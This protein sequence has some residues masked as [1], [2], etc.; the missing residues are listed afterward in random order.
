MY[1]NNPLYEFTW[2]SKEDPIVKSFHSGT[3]CLFY[4]PQ[5]RFDNVVT[6]QRLKDLVAWARSWLEQEGL[7][8]F[9]ADPQNHYDVANL[10][11]LNMWIHDIRS[12]GIVKPWMMLDQGDGTFLAGTGDSRLRCLERI[13][14]IQTVS[15]FITTRADRAHLYQGLE[16][17]TNFDRFA[18]ICNAVSGQGFLFRY[19]DSDAPY[20]IYWY[21]YNTEQTRNVT[22]GQSQA[23]TMFTNYMRRTPEVEITEEWFDFVIDWSA[24]A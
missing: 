22:P 20:G 7:D 4:N 11:K 8:K 3:H 16:A 21:E 15:A 13:P 14:E 18:E 10:V 23:V 17:V 12:Q 24:H 6:N 2:P 9:V 19:T 5:T 1:W